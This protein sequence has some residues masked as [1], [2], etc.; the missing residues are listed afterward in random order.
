[1]AYFDVVEGEEERVETGEV[2]GLEVDD[3]GQLDS[4][5]VHSI[6]LEV[7]LPVLLGE[8]FFPGLQVAHFEFNCLQILRILGDMRA[9]GVL[10]MGGVAGGFPPRGR[11]CFGRILDGR[12]A[13]VDEAGAAG[14]ESRRLRDVVAHGAVAAGGGRQVVT[15][16]STTFILHSLNYIYCPSLM[17]SSK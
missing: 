4:H 3:A 5:R 15:L 7:F 16:R 12:S 13:V 11:I 17:I 2:G 10:F 14:V 8:Q 6:S 9:I 1:V